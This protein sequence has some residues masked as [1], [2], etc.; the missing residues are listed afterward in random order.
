MSY[1]LPEGYVER[2][3]APQSYDAGGDDTW[4]REVYETALALA[5]VFGLRNVVDFGCGSG[6]KLVKNFSGPEFETIGIDLEPAVLLLRQRYPYCDWRVEDDY[7]QL[8][9]TA[10]SGADL[11]ICSDVIEHIDEPDKLLGRLKLAHHAWFVISTPDRKL[12][13]RYPKWGVK[14]GPPANGC[15]VREWS[16]E[17]FRQYMDGHFEVLRHFIANREQCTQVVI[18][19]LK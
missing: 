7:R 6:F 18:A 19:R 16:F 15:H 11:V 9:L 2:I 1:C 10:L 5:R 14:M 12:L 3:G 8:P 4:Q 13:E 17:E